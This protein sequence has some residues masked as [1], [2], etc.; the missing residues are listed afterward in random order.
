MQL[1]R[2]RRRPVAAQHLA[3]RM[4]VSVRTVYR[5]TDERVGMGAAIDGSA[6]PKDLRDKIGE[7]GLWAQRPRVPATAG[8]IDL[9]V[10]REAVRCER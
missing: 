9:G 10:V 2:G 3:D 5:D 6:A 8:G 7:I 4:S 1:L